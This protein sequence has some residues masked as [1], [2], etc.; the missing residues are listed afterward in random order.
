MC[1][2]LPRDLKRMD[3]TM[4]KLMKNLSVLLIPLS[5]YLL[6]SIAAP[7]RF[8]HINSMFVIFQQSLIPMVIGLGMCFSM[9]AGLFDLSVGAEIILAS[10][11]GGM[12]C[13][14]FGLAGL[15][16]GCILG[17]VMITLI[18]GTLY[19]LLRIPSLV[20]SM[21]M[22]MVYEVISTALLGRTGLIML[23]KEHSFLGNPPYNIM[24]VAVACTIFYL[25]FYRTK[26]S[27]HLRA[28]GSEERLAVSVGI[29]AKKIKFLAYLSGGVFIGIAALMTISFAGSA[30]TKLNMESLTMVFQPMMGL[31][32]GLELQRSTNLI[33]GIFI[34]E[35]AIAM[36]FTGLI[37]MGMPGTMQDVVL[38][39]FLLIVMIITNNRPAMEGVSRRIKNRFARK[40]ATNS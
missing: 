5:L 19:R 8:G 2:P 39:M 33:V 38:G 35:F 17:G 10:I 6:F 3:I 28:V 36:I 13:S 4:K 30:G 23:A 14:R 9:T 37:A 31:M 20:V 34:G 32:I 24:I 26:F 18:T 21:G 29:N 22:V 15:I 12:A 25:L 7:N 16:I 27:H 1:H 11:L 40:P